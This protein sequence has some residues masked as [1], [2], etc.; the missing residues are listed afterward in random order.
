MARKHGKGKHRKIFD[1]RDLSDATD[2]VLESVDRAVVA[3]AFKLRNEMRDVFKKDQ[4][5]YKYGTEKYY[6]M[7]EG[8]MVGKLRNG[9]VKIHGF[10]P[11]KNDGTWKARFFIVGTDYRFNSSGRKGLIVKNEA[12]DKGF[13]NAEA[14]LDS[15]IKKAIE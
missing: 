5:M 2:E 11:K 13:N 7:A 3:A 1:T 14:I 15:Y 9:H 4:S 10:G 12:I 6:R 8:I